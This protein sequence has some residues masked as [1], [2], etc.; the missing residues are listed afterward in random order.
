MRAQCTV[1]FLLLFSGV[2]AAETGRVVSLDSQRQIVGLELYDGKVRVE[3]VP[4]GGE[5]PNFAV[6]DKVDVEMTCAL[7]RRIR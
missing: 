4:I 2:L 6:G 1:V 5:F 7:D 3:F